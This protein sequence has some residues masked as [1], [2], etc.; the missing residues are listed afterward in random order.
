VSVT[1]SRPDRTSWPSLEIRFP[2]A[3]V[4]SETGG[5]LLAA[6]A[7][8]DL[9]A[10]E[11]RNVGAESPSST[12]AVEWRV[13]FRSREDR[14]LALR[15]VSSEFSHTGL[16]A[17]PTDLSDDGWAERTQT[18][19]TRIAVGDDLIVAPPWDVPGETTACVV[20]IQ[21]SM[22]FGTGH[23]ATTRLCLRLLLETAVPGRTLLDI[24]TGSGVLALAAWRLGGKS[25][26][27]V[28]NDPDAIES[29]RENLVLNGVS[30]G[31]GLVLGD[32]RTLPLQP[33]DIVTANLTASVLSRHASILKT[34]VAP[35]GHLILSGFSPADTH[36]VVT[37]F[38]MDLIRT[39]DEEDWSAALLERGT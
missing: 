34:L 28:D 31:L 15:L 33:S 14:D 12:P 25:V 27:A 24:G 5:L 7:D 23:H 17:C 20:V 21:P 13:S 39:M 9:S 4:E 3:D 6:I 26:V 29:A 1:S 37:S 32:F 10:V 19:L 30:A 18:G 36:E 38:R 2:N 16:E 35:G 22:G 11:E 8:L